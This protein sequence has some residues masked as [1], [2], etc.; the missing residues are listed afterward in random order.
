MV[1]EEE[2]GAGSSS[3]PSS[4]CRQAVSDSRTGAFE[5]LSKSRCASESTQ[6]PWI[7]TMIE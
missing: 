6:L 4:S 3:G 2:E 7:L 5:N 1:L